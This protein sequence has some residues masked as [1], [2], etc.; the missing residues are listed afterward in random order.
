MSKN[1]SL[2]TPYDSV[3]F[4]GSIKGKLTLFYLLNRSRNLDRKVPGSSWSETEPRG[5][6]DD[7][8]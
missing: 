7:T 4:T 5:H 6:R 2:Q 1:A 3:S 8:C